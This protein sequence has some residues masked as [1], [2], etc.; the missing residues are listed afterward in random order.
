MRNRAKCKLCKSIIES[1]HRHDYVSCGC[2]EIS[3]S[4]GN[5][6]LECSSKDWKNFLRVDDLGNEIVVKVESKMESQDSIDSIIPEKKLSKEDLLKEL[7]T[8]IENIE[9]LPT[10]AMSMPITHY[11]FL[12]SLL[13]LKLFFDCKEDI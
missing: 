3:I 11:D 6:V 13:L 2:G 5:E 12:S 4:G 7:S 8:M 10:N 9:K 1:F